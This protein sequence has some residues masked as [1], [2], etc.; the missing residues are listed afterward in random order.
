MLVPGDFNG[1]GKTD[2]PLHGLESQSLLNEQPTD[3]CST[4]C[5]DSWHCRV[6]LGSP[7]CPSDSREAM[8]AS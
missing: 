6:Q 8:E 1:D 7:P 5:A 3:R 2:V 4:P